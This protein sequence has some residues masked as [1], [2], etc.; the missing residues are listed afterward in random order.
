MPIKPEIRDRI[1]TAANALSAEGVENPTNDQVREQMGGGSLSHISPVMREWREG[2]KAAVAVA[3]DM[4]SELKKAVQTAIGQV[5]PV[6][7][8]LAAATWE[9]QRQELEEANAA[10]KADCDE[11]LAAVAELERVLS[12]RESQLHDRGAQV[13]DM[14]R[15]L[16]VAQAAITALEA[17]KKVLEHRL[18]DRDQ[19]IASLKEGTKL[20]RDEFKDLQARLADIVKERDAA[21]G[22]AEASQ[23]RLGDMD[24]LLASQADKIAALGGELEAV[25]SSLVSVE[26][27]KQVMERRL[28]DRDKMNINLQDDIALVR[29]EMKE[30]QAELLQ[31][32]KAG[33]PSKARPRKVED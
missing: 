27:E 17:D 19:E 15:Q 4:P 21:L 12:E 13:D 32:A 7:S 5:W 16:D 11:A 8:K 26:A 22:K 33:K 29:G 18:T 1:I 23:A 6:A 30:L 14:K 28:E 3:L 9:G 24:N 20:A 10:I 25:R 2:R 31:I